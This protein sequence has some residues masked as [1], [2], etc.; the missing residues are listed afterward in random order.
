MYI[1]NNNAILQYIHNFEKEKLIERGKFMKKTKIGIT[2]AAIIAVAGVTYMCSTFASTVN[3]THNF[4]YGNASLSY[5][6]PLYNNANMTIV[7]ENKENKYLR[8]SYNG[9]AGRGRKYYDVKVADVSPG[10]ILQVEYDVMY[11]EINTEKN[12]EVQIKYRT[13][14]GTAETDMVTRVGKHNGYFRTQNIENKIT[15]IKKLD[16]KTLTIE[17]GHWYSIKIIVDED[18]QSVYVFNR[19]TKELLAYSEPTLTIGGNTF[20][21]MVTFSSET[22]MCLDNIHIYNTS[23]ERACIYGS[24]YV[25]SATKNTYYLFGA[26]TDGNYTALPPGTTTWSL[27]TPHSGV[28]VDSPTGRI[29]VD[30]KPEPGPVVLKAERETADGKIITAKYVVNVS[31]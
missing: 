28:S 24:P 13:G 25:T 18:W 2:A 10:G 1:I 6:T 11:P 31:K 8:L 3:V 23:Y 15:A 27:E 21:N 17:T 4:E 14:P 5:L 22:D 7:E 30:S 12:G 19:D 16:G 9:N 26:D 20:I 29:I